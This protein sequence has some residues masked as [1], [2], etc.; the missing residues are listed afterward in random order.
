MS[1]A[2]GGVIACGFAGWDRPARDSVAAPE[3]F[4]DRG[5][6]TGFAPPDRGL[7][8]RTMAD[9][10]PGALPRGS[11]GRKTC[12]VHALPVTRGLQAEDARMKGEL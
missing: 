10:N 1:P 7:P 8:R 12:R 9:R 2:G 4:K 6:G 11:N 3:V 5:P